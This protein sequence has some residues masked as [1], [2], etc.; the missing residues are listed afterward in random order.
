MNPTLFFDNLITLF[1]FACVLFILAAI[2]M[3]VAAFTEEPCNCAEIRRHKAETE[4]TK[5]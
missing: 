2:G 5:L 3:A 1:I 4:G